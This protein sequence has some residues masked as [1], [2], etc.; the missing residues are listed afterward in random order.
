MSKPFQ[1]SMRGMFLAV[2]LVCWIAFLAAA[3]RGGDI[4]WW[5]LR[6]ALIF[7]GAVLL[8]SRNVVCGLV[9]GIV[10]TVMISLLPKVY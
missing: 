10:L 9:V 6:T 3:F 2:T 1:F 4:E 5:Q 8:V 7:A